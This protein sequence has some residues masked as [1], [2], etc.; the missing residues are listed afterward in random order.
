[1]MDANSPFTMIGRRA[2]IEL[3]RLTLDQTLV[4]FDVLQELAAA[5]WAA[6]EPELSD[7]VAKHLESAPS[8]LYKD[9]AS[10]APSAPAAIRLDPDVAM[11]G[12]D[13]ALDDSILF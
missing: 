4:L 1:M 9:P 3:P 11:S 6:H 13:P 12:S 10:R 2:S 7:Y 8:A 5:I